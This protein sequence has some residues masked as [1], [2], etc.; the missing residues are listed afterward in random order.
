MWKRKTEED[1]KKAKKEKEKEI[2]FLGLSM[3]DI[4]F[5]LLLA[6]FFTF[7]GY[8]AEPD[9]LSFI[10][11]CF[12]LTFVA[13]CIGVRYFG[14]PA[15]IFTMLHFGTTSS[16]YPSVICN[17]CHSVVPRSKNEKCECGG[18]YE[19]LENWKWEE[20]AIVETE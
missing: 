11:S 17:V 16:L 9:D 4:L 8:V 2:T 10:I 13:C 15:A 12:V 14:S 6:I 5:S 3:S 18:R 20:D 19:P 1:Y 7:C